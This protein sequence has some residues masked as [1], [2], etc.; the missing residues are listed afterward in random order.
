MNKYQ[1]CQNMFGPCLQNAKIIKRLNAVLDNPCEATWDDAHSI[2]VGADGF[3]TLW[4]CVIAVD[5]F[6]PRTG[7]RTDD[8]GNVIRRWERV[9]DHFTLRRALKFAR[10][11]TG[12]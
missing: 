11:H 2:I 10:T 12:D 3:T 8:K 9:P 4:Q 5:P 6:F 1:G 7:P